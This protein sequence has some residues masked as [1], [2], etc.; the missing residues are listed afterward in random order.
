M[1]IADTGAIVA[2]VDRADRHH[3]TVR[4][5]FEQLPDE[6]VLPWAILPEVDY[7]LATHVGRKAE[8]VFLQD[9]AMGAFAVEWGQDDDLDAA[10]RILATHRSLAMGLV[11]ATVMAITVRR[12]A[13]AIA[14]LDLRHFGEVKLPGAPRLIPR[15]LAQL[16]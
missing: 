2:L 10:V 6:W 12:R 1:I 8:D 9:L 14:T 4:Q 16:A 11:D 3:Q 13:R 15:D 7:L 5:A